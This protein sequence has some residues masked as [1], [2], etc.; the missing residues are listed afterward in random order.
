MDEL[1]SLKAF[2]LLKKVNTSEF[3]EGVLGARPSAEEM[4]T[5]E[6]LLELA[7]EQFPLW[8]IRYKKPSKPSPRRG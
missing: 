1:R 2:S 6:E 3:F 8:L 7:Q 5:D 4:R